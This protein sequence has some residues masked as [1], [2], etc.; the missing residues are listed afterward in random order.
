[1]TEW[2]KRVR[3]F[4]IPYIGVALFIP[5][6]I[7]KFILNDASFSIKDIN[8]IIPASASFF[9][10]D[11]SARVSIF[12]IS[13]LL[14]ILLTPLVS[15]LIFKIRSRY[16]FLAYPLKTINKLSSFSILL[17]I[18]ELIGVGQPNALT[19]IAIIIAC[20]CFYYLFAYIIKSNLLSIR[21]SLTWIISLSISLS[22]FIRE[23]FQVLNHSILFHEAIIIAFCVCSL[24][25]FILVDKCNFNIKSIVTFTIPFY[26]LPLLPVISTELYLILNQNNIHCLSAQIYYTSGIVILFI[27][28]IIISK[29]KFFYNKYTIDK[30]LNIIAIPILL[31]GIFALILYQPFIE[32]PL[33]PFELANTANGMMRM[34]MFNEFPFIQSFSSH[35][36][37][38]YACYPIYCLLCGYDHSLSF[39]VYKFIPDIISILI[40]YY[41]LQHIFKNGLLAL[42]AIVFIP[43][44][45]YF[46]LKNYVYIF[47][48]VFLFYE[49]FKTQQ[50]KYIVYI[51][52]A[53]VFI[54][55]WK[56]ELAICILSIITCLFVLFFIQNKFSKHL[57]MCLVKTLSILV[58][59]AVIVLLSLV[60]F[61]EIEIF[62]NF[63]QAL[64]YLSANQAHGIEEITYK[65]DR[66]YYLHYFIFPCI[67]AIFFVFYLI[68]LYKPVI[69]KNLLLNIL[70]LSLIIFYFVNFQRGLVRHSFA[71]GGESFTTSF[72]YWIV[73]LIIYERFFKSSTYIVFIPLLMFFIVFIFRNNDEPDFN[74]LYTKIENKTHHISNFQKYNYKVNRLIGSEE[75]MKNNYSDL[76]QFLDTNF[77]KEA[78]FIDFSNTPMLYFYTQR[79]VPSYFNQ[80]M[81]NTVNYKLQKDNIKHLQKI[82]IPVVIY[83]NIPENWFD[84][85]DGVPNNLR[86]YLISDYIFKNYKP[87][88]NISHH[89]IWL[90]KDINLPAISNI[91]DSD[92]YQIR[93]YK[94]HYYPWL[95][96]KKYQN[97]NMEIL[98]TLNDNSF[99]T[100]EQ[101]SRYANVVEI[102]LPEQNENN[103]LV[104]EFAKDEQVLGYFEFNIIQSKER[105][106]Y[107]LPIS[108]IYNWIVFD[109]SNF[110]LRVLKNNEEIKP[111]EIKILKELYL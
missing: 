10:Y 5:L 60:L 108:T 75:F 34:F 6:L 96:A 33:E 21:Q 59:F 16:T 65:Y 107:Y 102:I 42:A 29:I 3:S 30:Q 100:I 84:C 38:D 25:L 86:Y 28:A 85:T 27:I 83:S 11:I 72:F 80:Y 55:L 26:F 8:L 37:S 2:I 98:R 103:L 20:V 13:I 64:S 110:R 68:K 105:Q 51:I 91:S 18:S 32:Q 54:G 61:T 14:V 22:F 90:K 74:Y 101:D 40:V 46:Y 50:K 19:F 52:L 58:G 71:E 70:I 63:S 79:R 1:M 4:K 41:L 53:S 23:L 15:L 49:L 62:S 99:E 104:F 31:I 9:N 17:I 93:Y 35:L 81:Q 57:V 12:Y 82:D 88:A 43:F 89:Q 44:I 7:I 56:A 109:C 95:L 24:I 66:F 78:S 73:F 106:K 111:I 36:L 39:L 76:K 47:C 45:D 87:Y 69:N 67:L 94:L 77:N 92:L 97:N 48:I